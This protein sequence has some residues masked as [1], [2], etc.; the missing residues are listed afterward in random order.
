MGDMITSS[1]VSAIKGLFKNQ[2]FSYVNNRVIILEKQFRNETTPSGREKIKMRIKELLKTK[3][4]LKT[5]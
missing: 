5:L 2:M 3:S 1:E 4:Y